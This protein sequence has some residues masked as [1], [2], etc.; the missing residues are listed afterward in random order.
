MASIY[1]GFN[2]GTEG[3]TISDFT[4]GASSGSTDMELRWDTGKS[5]TRLDL[6]KF[7]EAVKDLYYNTSVNN[8]GPTLPQL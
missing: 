1:V 3:F 8:G 4:T 7:L 6:E 5:L 2:R